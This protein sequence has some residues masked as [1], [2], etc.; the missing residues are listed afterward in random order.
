MLGDDDRDV[1]L[2]VGGPVV[3]RVLLVIHVQAVIHQPRY[4]RLYEIGRKLQRWT[5]TL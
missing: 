1:G 5:M 4:Q 3:E 2:V